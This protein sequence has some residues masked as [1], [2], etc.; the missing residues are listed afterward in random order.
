MKKFVSIIIPVYN[1]EKYINNICEMLNN[2]T[3]KNFEAIF[4]NDNSND[5]SLDL[6][7]KNKEKYS[8][9]KVIS[10]D[11]NYGAGYSRNKAI[12][13]AKYDYISF[14]DVDD[15]IDNNY[16]EEMVNALDDNDMVICDINVKYK[17]VY[18]NLSDN[19]VNTCHKLPVEKVD[20]INNSLAAAAWNK[21]IKK[22][23]ILNNL[24]SVGIIN[25]DIPAIIGSILDSNKIS[26]T[27]KTHY[28]YIQRKASVQNS[29]NI[30]KKFDIFKAVDELF[31]RKKISKEYKDIIIYNQLIL[32]LFYGVIN[33]NISSYSKYLKMYNQLIKKYNFKE[34]KYY[35]SFINNQSKKVKLYYKFIVFF[36]T[37]GMYHLSSLII[38][39]GRSLN[40]YKNNNKKSVIKD[41]ITIN[42]IVN[43]AKIN[44]D[45]KSKESVSVVIPNYNYSKYLYQRLYSI[46]NQDYKI[47]EIIILDDNSSDN[48]KDIIEEIKNNI[49]NIIDIKTIYNEKNSGCVFKQW[50]KGFNCSSSSF[51]WIAEADDYSS[52]NFL[53]NV[54]KPMEEDDVVLSYCDTSF[55]NSNG[56]IIKK[57]VV[58]QIDIVNTN[59][60][61]KSYIN[62]G[63]NE[64]ENYMFLNCTIA[65]VS[66]V[67][68][69]KI[70]AST[71][72]KEATNYKQCGDWY[73]YY[74]YIKNHKIAYVNNTYN[75]CRI[76]GD[77]STSNLNK[78]IHYEEIKTIQNKIM[79]EFNVRSNANIMIKKRLDYLKKVWDITDID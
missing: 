69:R 5:S 20:V 15:E 2:Q 14:L 55:V 38:K 66:S 76:H 78:K 51:V 11:K 68:F 52:P 56:Q 4:I 18:D 74:N 24:F 13:M 72:F 71:F 7:Y 30:T 29:N 62:D 79:N 44:K 21:I 1:G 43:A 73:F 34:N 32:F 28:N 47:S 64:I 58:D 42:D 40:N 27:N 49:K 25:E 12:E 48:S 70:N 59:H 17:E 26:Y 46:L 54:I 23:I 9:I 50:E 31:K 36:M 75:Y 22:E 65:N 63:N 19:Y 53:T 61:N 37:K 39:L 3:Y 16:Y 41:N 60:W 45:I 10:N 8:F 77:N 67:L 57:S 6:L 35:N 33:L